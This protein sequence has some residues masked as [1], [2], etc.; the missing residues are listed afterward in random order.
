MDTQVKQTMI[1]IRDAGNLVNV[2]FWNEDKPSLVPAAGKRISF[3]RFK[4]KDSKKRENMAVE[5]TAHDSD[6]FQGNEGHK[7]LNDL[8]ADFQD[9]VLKNVADKTLSMDVAED[10]AKLIAEYY[11]V[12]RD[13]S[14]R[15]ITKEA[16]AEF[17]IA[18]CAQYVTTRAIQKNA[19]MSADTM[20]KVLADYAAM[21]GKLTKYDIVNAF[22]Q[23]QIDLINRILENTKGESESEMRT[24]ILGRMA[25]IVELKTAQDN[26]VDMI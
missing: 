5:V 11:D 23:N 24:W 15:K 21:F 16:I 19:Q 6:A 26:L 14:G 3:L 9:S 13:G 1:L 10:Q 20:A 4:A 18:E 12:S 17:F 2:T 22:Q 25:K 8:I 7:F